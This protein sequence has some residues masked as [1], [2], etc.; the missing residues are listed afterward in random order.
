MIGLT[1]SYL[2]NIHNAKK[3]SFPCDKIAYSVENYCSV[4]TL[5]FYKFTSIFP[6][7]R[8]AFGPVHTETFSC[9]FVLFTV[10]K[11]IENNQLITW[12]NT[13]TQDKV[14]VLLSFS[15]ALDYTAL[16]LNWKR[17]LT[18]EPHASDGNMFVFGLES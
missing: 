8:D 5:G 6:T 9:V 7:N 3:I 4:E 14:L 16:L 13:K 10:L 11:E 1:F 15:E 17:F 12:N 2:Y 18:I